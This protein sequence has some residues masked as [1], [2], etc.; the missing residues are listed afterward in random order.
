ME[1][2]VI[3]V[4]HTWGQNLSL[5]PHIHCIVPALGYSIRGKMKHIGKTGK[6]L[7]PVTQL[8]LKFRGRFMDGVKKDYRDK[9]RPKITS[10]GGEEFLRRFCMHILPR[11]F[12]KIRHYGIYSLRFLATIMKKGGKMVI[13]QV[14]TT[15]ERIN[16][17]VGVDVAR[18]PRCR[19]GRLIPAGVIPRSRSPTLPGLNPFILQ[20]SI[21]A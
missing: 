5:H 10:L 20:R 15:A 1:S 19:K 4:L 12:V 16:R 2:G 17:L 6:Y 7:Y 11:G 9:G 3:C 13:R 8:S 21:P 18:C 14:E